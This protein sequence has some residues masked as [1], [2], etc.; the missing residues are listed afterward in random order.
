[1]QWPGLVRKDVSDKLIMDPR[2]AAALVD[3]ASAGAAPD[4]A[5][6]GPGPSSPGAVTADA[7]E[8][9]GE[10]APERDEAGEEALEREMAD[11]EKMMAAVM[12]A[13]ADALA[14]DD[15]NDGD[16]DGEITEGTRRRREI[17]AEVATRMLQ[18]F[19]L[20]DADD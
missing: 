20:G 16:G 6:D 12:Q 14:A 15:L 10:G 9:A 19:G 17:A 5:P 18:Q 7:R 13:R 8:E 2:E 4:S 3:G 11:F 1:M